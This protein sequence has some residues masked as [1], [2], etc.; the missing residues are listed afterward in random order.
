MDDDRMDDA[1]T[2]DLKDFLEAPVPGVGLT[3]TECYRIAA[4]IGQAKLEGSKVDRD[5]ILRQCF[6][7]ASAR[8]AQQEGTPGR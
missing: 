8:R 5:A 6:A 4:L 3:P 1:F 2:D 7:E